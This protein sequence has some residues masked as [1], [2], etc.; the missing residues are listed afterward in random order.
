MFGAYNR[1]CKINTVFRLGVYHEK[2][3][4]HISACADWFG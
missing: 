2:I 4:V 1:D 3:E